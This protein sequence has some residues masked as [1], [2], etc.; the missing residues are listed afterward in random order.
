M[1]LMG[2]LVQCALMAAGTFAIGSI[3]LH[4][5]SS[6]PP[7][8][9]RQRGS[10][11][12]G[13]ATTATSSTALSPGSGISAAS[14]TAAAAAA[15]SAEFSSSAVSIYSISLLIGTALAVIIPE[16]LAIIQ[17][18]AANGKEGQ[19]EGEVHEHVG[20]GNDADVGFWIGLALCSGFLLMWVPP[21]SL[22]SYSMRRHTC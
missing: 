5:A 18:S 16:G 6:S 17:R 2:L 9:A 3:P 15:A 13:G 19:R 21:S 20:D 4:L 12:S 22:P 11:S 7:P 14:S 1:A 10:S 8:A